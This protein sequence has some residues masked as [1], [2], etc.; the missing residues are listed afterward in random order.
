MNASS[1]ATAIQ[2][3]LRLAYAA[4]AHKIHGHT[5]KKP[6]SLVV[7]L[8]TW[9]QPAMAYVML[10]SVQNLSQ[11]YIIESIAAE[12]IRPWP[13]ALEQVCRM[14]DIDLSA[15]SEGNRTLKIVSLNMLSLRSHF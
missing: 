12:K 2:Y 3:P 6:Q 4:T 5:V 15:Q 9:L 14:R 7:D 11:L 8:I 10:S 13:S 1:T